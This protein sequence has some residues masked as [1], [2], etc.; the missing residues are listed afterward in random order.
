MNQWLGGCSAKGGGDG[1]EAVVD[2]LYD[3]LHLPWRAEAAK[4]CI[5][6]ADAPPHGAYP[7]GGD[8]FPDGCPCG[9]DPM[10]IAREMA[11]KKIILYTVGVEPPIGKS[12]LALLYTFQKLSYSFFLF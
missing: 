11:A 8:L 3:A 6:I 7:E 5:I 4:I 2:E 9:H 10:T 1:P 12:A